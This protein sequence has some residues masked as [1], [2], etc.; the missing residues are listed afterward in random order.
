MKRIGADLILHPDGNLLPGQELIL[1]DR[2][3]VVDLLNTT[4]NPD[5][6]FTGTL[7]PAFINTHCHLELSQY[8]NAIPRHTG[9]HGFVKDI[10]EI[11]RTSPVTNSPDIA[12][13]DHQMWE[14]GIQAVAD[15]SNTN[16][17][18][19]VKSKSKIIYHSLIELFDIDPTRAKETF[20]NGLSLYQKAKELQLRA[21]LTPHAPYTVSDDLF[22]M[23]QE[24][25]SEKEQIFS[26][27]SL[28]SPSENELVSHNTGP[29]ANFMKKAGYLPGKTEYTGSFDKSL[30]FIPEKSNC[31]FIHNTFM[32]AQDLELLKS[33]AFSDRIWFALC[34]NANLYIENTLPDVPLFLKHK[35]QLT[36]GTDSLASNATLSVLDEIKVLTDAFPQISAATLLTMATRNGADFMKLDHLGSFRKGNKPGI[37]NLPQLNTDQ[38]VINENTTVKRLL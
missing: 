21:S 16:F 37:L 31:I 24:F 33:T 27:H 20:H 12:R 38:P 9:L 6:Y 7:C 36:I 8:L 28:E 23:I 29:L 14:A 1:N 22:R 4:G 30:R 15:I 11:Y 32:N 3:E 25:H 13:A 2:N 18:F 17:T 10:L 26:L 34:P 35:L 19:E 5:E